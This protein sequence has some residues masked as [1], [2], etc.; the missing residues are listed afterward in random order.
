MRDLDDAEII[1]KLVVRSSIL[2]GV[3]MPTM[4]VR[5]TGN[6]MVKV[7]LGTSWRGHVQHR[8]IWGRG[9]PVWVAMDS[10]DRTSSMTTKD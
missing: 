1:F 7:Y 2:G 4:L 3:E 6:T 8:A 9:I 5:S 10:T